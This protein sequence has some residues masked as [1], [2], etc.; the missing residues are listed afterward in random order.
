M[1]TRGCLVSMYRNLLM[2]RPQR[3][4]SNLLFPHGKLRQQI[5]PQQHKQLYT[6]C[7]RLL[8]SS[9]L[10]QKIP[11]WI[12]AVKENPQ[13]QSQQQRYFSTSNV[14]TDKAAATTVGTSSSSSSSSSLH[15][16]TT[17]QFHNVLIVIK[18]TAYEEYS[19]VK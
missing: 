5:H 14:T 11:T 9:H 18:Q 3:I 2:Q 12:D 8:S 10:T 4:N 7:C 19:Q 13:L 16:S 17:L 15:G 6:I 1:S